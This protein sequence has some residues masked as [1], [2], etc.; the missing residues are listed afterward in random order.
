MIIKDFILQPGDGRETGLTDISR[1]KVEGMAIRFKGDVVRPTKTKFDSSF[2]DRCV[3]RME[4]ANK[5][6]S[7]LPMSGDNTAQWLIDS[8]PSNEVLNGGPLPWSPRNIEYVVK[9]YEELGKKYNNHQLCKHIHIAGG[10][11]AT[12]SEELHADTGW[13]KTDAP[14]IVDAYKDIIDAVKANFKTQLLWLAI[15][16]QKAAA[17]YVNPIVDYGIN[18]L[19]SRFGVKNNSLKWDTSLSADHNVIVVNAAK[20]GTHMG[21]EMAKAQ[22]TKLSKAVEKATTMAKAAKVGEVIIFHYPPDLKYL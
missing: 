1:P 22:A 3:A 2:I 19:G 5:P 4:K 8:L 21:F 12:T 11:R 6:F 17:G 14:K 16:G 7:L 9:Y 20:R 10:T 13:K 15:S 18:Q